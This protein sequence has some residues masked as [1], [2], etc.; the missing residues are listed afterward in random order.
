MAVC[1]WPAIVSIIHQRALHTHDRNSLF[2]R[3]RQMVC[4]RGRPCLVLLPTE[5]RQP[6]SLPVL[7]LRRSTTL[8]ECP[9]VALTNQ[10]SN[11]DICD[12]AACQRRDLSMH[13]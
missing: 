2:N 8:S 1:Q 5:R 9:H 11:L 3:S 10:A 13:M 4:C 6:I 12:L 7:L